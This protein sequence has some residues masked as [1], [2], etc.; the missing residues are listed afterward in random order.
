M[1]PDLL[2]PRFPHVPARDGHYE[3]IYLTASHP[4]EPVAVWIRY[5]V[6]KPPG[7]AS[8]GSIWFTLFEPTGP[9]AIKV[10]EKAPRSDASTGDLLAVGA[11]GAVRSDGA[12]GGVSAGDTS[13]S[14]DLAFE[15]TD[16]PLRHLPHNWMYG[17]ALPR[18]KSTSPYPSM[19][20]T[21][22]VTVAGR[23]LTLQGWRGMLG[24]NWGSEHAHRWIWLRAASFVEKPDAWLDVVIGRITVGRRVLPWIANGVFAPDGPGGVRHRVGG[25]ARRP[26]VSE[27][28]D[29]CD[30]VLPASGGPLTVRV[31]APL[32]TSVGW[33]YADPAGGRHQVRNCSIAAIE[34]DVPGAGRWV[35]AHGGVYELGSASFDPAVTMQPYPDGEQ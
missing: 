1:R 18:T 21:G 8:T 20:V 31:S 9:T 22:T 17:A 19:R 12:R 30:L 34:L 6:H 4:T 23:T 26:T 2:A 10:T 3:S 24:H 35:S 25:L 5:T 27:R 15:P 13:P 16:E 14:W 7:A 11:M 28:S 32:A 29:G 33:E